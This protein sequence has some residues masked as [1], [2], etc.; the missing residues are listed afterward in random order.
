MR[1]IGRAPFGRDPRDWGDAVSF[2]SVTR[3]LL[4]ALLLAADAGAQPVFDRLTR[5]DGLP[6]DYVL[7]VHQDRWGFLWFGTDA[8]AVRWDGRRTQV[9][10]IDDGLPHAY[11]RGFAE[12]ADGALWASTNGGAV[13]WTGA[14]WEAAEIPEALQNGVLSTDRE[15]RLVVTTGGRLARKEGRRWRTTRWDVPDRVPEVPVLDVGGGRLLVSGLLDQPRALLLTPEGDDTFRPSWLALPP[16]LAGHEGILSVFQAGDRWAGSVTGSSPVV[17]DLELAADGIR[18]ASAP[19]AGRAHRLLVGDDAALFALS[20]DGLFGVDP[21]SGITGPPLLDVHATS[22]VVDREGALWVGTFGRGVARLQSLGLVALTDRPALRVAV[23]GDAAWATGERAVVRVDLAGETPTATT[24][25]QPDTRAI[26]ARADGRLRLSSAPALHAPV[27]ARDLARPQALRGRPP[28]AR[29]VAG[30]VSGTVETADSLWMGSYGTGVRRFL[31][32]GDRLVEIDTVDAADG[33]PTS[34]VEGVARTRAGTWAVTRSGLALLRGPRARALGVADGLPSSSVHAV[35]EARDGTHWAGTDR[36][37]ARLDLAR[38]RAAGVGTRAM[39]GAPVVAMFERA[40]APGVLWAVTAKALWR[41]ADGRARLVPSAPLVRDRRHAIEAAAYHAVSDR[42][43]LATSGGVTVA[44]LAAV[45]PADPTA[46]SV[47]LARATVDDAAV[48][49]LGTPRDARLADLPPGRRRVVVEASALLFGSP[50]RVEWRGADGAWHVAEDGRITLPA[51]GAGDHLVEVRAVTPGGVASRETARLAFRVAPRWW[52]RRAAQALL[53]VLVLSA[54]V[55]G[56]RHASQRRLRARVRELELERRVQAERE[57]ISRDLHDHVGAEVAAIL[58]EAELARLDAA[59]AGRDVGAFRAVEQRAR[60]TMGSLREAIWALGHGALTPAAL[61]ERLGAFAQTQAR[62]AE[63]AVEARAIG[64]TGRAL[65]PMQAL[66]LYR[67]GQEAV[68][69][70]VRHS[71]G[72]RLVVTVEARRQR[73]AVVVRDDG[74]FGGPAG[75]GG[76]YGL[77]NMQARAEALGGSLTITDGD[78]TT[79]RAEIPVA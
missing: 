7:A 5:A 34:T 57:R 68:R 35:Y 64:E 11:V 63:L 61:A 33:L 29:D 25:P 19:R 4:L 78:G 77:G 53:A 76:G 27:S 13:R 18:A 50:A 37:V 3:A 23:A 9:F 28:A 16:G 17:F 22:A 73:V 46:P 66:A 58:T 26:S 2:R 12:T 65:A 49:L 69:N 44:S 20:R 40:A 79:V 54:L 21:Q 67:I 52:E 45:T 1:R 30:W 75:D 10:S 6:S 72:A 39:A 41:I 74:A 15:G 59:A 8:G 51:A 48:E 56:V 47:V 38:W 24:I 71:G 62:R 55:G 14:A 42:L 32:R 31:Q 70:A 43:V 60:R 36:G